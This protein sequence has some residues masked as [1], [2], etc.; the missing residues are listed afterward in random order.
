MKKVVLTLSESFP[1]THTRAGQPTNFEQLIREGK[2]IHT[3]RNNVEWWEMK[4]QKIN[5]GEMIISRRQWTGKPYNSLQREIDTVDHLALQLIRI[6]LFHG[7]LYASVYG[8]E[9]D[10]NQLAANDGL[11]PEDFKD[12]FFGKNDIGTYNGVILHFTD[13]R[14]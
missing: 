3:I 8:K 14:Y 6:H 4:A 11:S 2:K 12:W 7:K 1:A 13:F 10:P 5:A 9:V